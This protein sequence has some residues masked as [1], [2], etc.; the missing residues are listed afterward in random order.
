MVVHRAAPENARESLSVTMLAAPPMQASH[1]VGRGPRAALQAW[2]SECR[3][4]DESNQW[5]EDVRLQAI[6]AAM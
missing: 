3:T 5:L 6:L 1:A 4:A 2:S